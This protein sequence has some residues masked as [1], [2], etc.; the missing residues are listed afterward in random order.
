MKIYIVENYTGYPLRNSFDSLP[1]ARFF[2]NN[3]FAQMSC[4]DYKT[5]DDKWI[6]KNGELLGEI[7]V[8]EVKD[9]LGVDVNSEIDNVN[10]PTHYTQGGIECI[11]AIK[12]SMTHE[13]YFGYLKGNIIKY[14]WRYENKGG[15]ESLQK[16]QWYLN[17]LIE[18]LEG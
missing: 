12:A 3:L 13:A 14:M 8:K 6:G 1:A 18:E 10:H 4:L 15:E 9:N 5:D 11:D 7:I 16:A 17:R 2:G